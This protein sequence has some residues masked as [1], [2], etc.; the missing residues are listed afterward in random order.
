[1][2][3][4]KLLY[5]YALSYKVILTIIF[6]CM[7][8]LIAYNG[9]AFDHVSITLKAGW[10]M[11]SFPGTLA[12]TSPDSLVGANSQIILPMYM[13]DPESFSYVEATEIE[14]GKGYWILTM[15]AETL[16]ADITF[17]SSYTMVLKA[18][19]NMIGSVYSDVNF[20]DPQDAPDGSVI[21]PIYT[22]SPTSFGYYEDTMI[23][24]GMG[25]WVLALQDCSLTVGEVIPIEEPGFI[26]G[27]V[28]DASNDLPLEG[29]KIAVSGIAGESLSGAD[30]KY[31][32]PVPESE[33][34]DVTI[35]RV[36][37]TTFQ[38]KIDAVKGRDVAMKTARLTPLDTKK[39]IIT[40]SEGGVAT[41]STGTIKLDIPQGLSSKRRMWR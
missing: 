8:L 30:G 17:S 24:T 28:V 25:Y 15:V 34:Y 4:A 10:N 5:R 20:S 16:T 2:Q 12:D 19:W 36:G 6:V 38:H 7:L 14:P 31:A 32:Y 37:Y 39:N 18:G 3:N 9:Y 33:E 26:D 27:L 23:E 29:A 13:Y 11:V 1:M 35:S 22:Y 21:L 40:P 41:D